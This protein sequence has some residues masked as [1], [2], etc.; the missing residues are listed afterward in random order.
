MRWIK[1]D[2]GSES[3]FPTPLVLAFSLPVMKKVTLAS[4]LS[5]RSRKALVY[6]LGPSS[7]VR[8]TVPGTVQERIDSG[9]YGTLPSLGR[10]MMSVDGPLGGTGGSQRPYSV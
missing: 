5:N 4:N 10:G 3:I 1:V 8:A 7:K 6:L 9:P 2:E